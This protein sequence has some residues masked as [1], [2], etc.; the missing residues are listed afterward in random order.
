MKLLHEEKGV[1]VVLVA[2]L[3]PVILL[4]FA[5]ALD[6]AGLVFAKRQVQTTADAAALAGA[7]QFE[8]HGEW[9]GERWE[10]VFTIQPEAEKEAQRAID[11]N[12]ENFRF[13][14]R[15]ID[16]DWYHDGIGTDT[17][18]VYIDI[19]MPTMLFWGLY[20]IFDGETGGETFKFN[21]DAAVKVQE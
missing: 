19:E 11:Y 7:S 14:A 21:V 9:D 3:L 16:L 17:F 20:G 10:P 18:F 2:L 8:V 5:L 13:S 1:S 4:F 12:S 6:V 15:D